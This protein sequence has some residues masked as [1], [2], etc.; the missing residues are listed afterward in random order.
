VI[1]LFSLTA[2]FIISIS[3]ICTTT[4]IFLPTH[5][6][7]YVCIYIYTYTHTHLSHDLH[8]Y[9]FL[10]FFIAFYIIVISDSTS[11]IDNLQFTSGPFEGRVYRAL[12]SHP[13][14]QTVFHLVTNH[15][16]LSNKHGFCRV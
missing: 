6:H 13:G 10:L 8:Q 4:C 7:K 5:T 16:A 9:H 3:N 14:G 12:P 1:N 15:I 2:V 11:F